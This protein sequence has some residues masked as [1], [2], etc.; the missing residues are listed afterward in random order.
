MSDKTDF[1]L[2]MIKWDMEGHHIMINVSIH[3]EAIT[4][5]SI[6][7]HNIGVPKHIKQS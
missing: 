6:H 2:K 4:I 1:E 3:Q 5:M 7:S